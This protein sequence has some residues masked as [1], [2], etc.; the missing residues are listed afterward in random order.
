MDVVPDQIGVEGRHRGADEPDSWGDDAAA[1]L[2]HEERRPDR[3]EDLR[4]TD[5][6]PVPPE[7][8]VDRYEEEAVQRLGVRGRVP[9]DKAV[10][11]RSEERAGEVVALVREGREDVASLDAQR[12]QAR[13]GDD[14]RE[15]GI[16]NAAAHA[17]ERSQGAGRG[18]STL[19]P[20]STKPAAPAAPL[21]VPPFRTRGSVVRPSARFGR[22]A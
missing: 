1:D 7:D 14:R 11:P 3:D 19:A 18:R 2:V 6:F 4:D 10:R 15:Q 20:V 5:D 13:D 12:D 9:G 16:G 17:R 8:P 21:T 22:S